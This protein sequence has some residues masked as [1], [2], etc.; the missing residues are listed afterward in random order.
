MS[1]KTVA[2]AVSALIVI[3]I[4]LAMA[5]VYIWEKSGYKLSVN[6]P[7]LTSRGDKAATSQKVAEIQAQ[8]QAPPVPQYYGVFLWDGQTLQEFRNKQDWP[9]RHILSAKLSLSNVKISSLRP[10]FVIFDRSLRI[11]APPTVEVWPLKHV[12]QSIVSAY[13]T[14]N[15]EPK[16]YW[17]TDKDAVPIETRPAPAGSNPEMVRIVFVGDLINSPGW[18]ALS[19]QSSAFT[20]GVQVDAFDPRTSLVESVLADYGSGNEVRLL[21]L[22]TYLRQ[23]PAAAT[24]S[25]WECPPPTR[26]ASPA[27]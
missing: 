11:A 21:S 22:G 12:V 8:A 4:V 27:Q 24:G 23:H 20:F 25:D 10:S 15:C 5:G 2:A 6:V 14:A 19:M 26:F 1:K 18:Y 7:S 17:T 13:N 3:A 9:D 16:D